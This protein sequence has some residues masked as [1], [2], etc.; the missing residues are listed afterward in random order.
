MEAFQGVWNDSRHLPQSAT[1][2]PPLHD[3]NHLRGPMIEVLHSSIE[4]HF[5]NINSSHVQNKILISIAHIV[6]GEVL[7][8]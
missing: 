5:R 3:K 1:A 4:A 8:H 7:F 6:A 2:V